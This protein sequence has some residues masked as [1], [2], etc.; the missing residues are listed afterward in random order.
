MKKLKAV[1]STS[2]L[3]TIF[4]MSKFPQINYLCK[5]IYVQCRKAKG[6]VTTAPIQQPL[7]QDNLGK[8]KY[9]KG[10]SSGISW[11]IC[12]SFRLRSRQITT[13]ASH[14]SIYIDALP[15][16]QPTVSKH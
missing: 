7:F 3:M 9:Q 11:T 6:L 5:S 1:R 15:D 4:S 13:P 12:K 10:R 14:H 8:K 2:L 16:A